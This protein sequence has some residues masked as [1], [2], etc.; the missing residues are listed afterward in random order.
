MLELF[1]NMANDKVNRYNERLTT[2]A[3]I[4][5]LQNQWNDVV[6]LTV[7]HDRTKLVGFSRLFS[8]F[9]R[10]TTILTNQSFMP[11]SKAEEKY[12]E[13]TYGKQVIDNLISSHK[14]SYDKLLS[15]LG[16]KLSSPKMHFTDSVAV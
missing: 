7:N 1:G 12:L 3:I 2:G 6:P 13:A 9:I 16:D 10:G 5:M 11:E 15:I 4:G 8:V 14:E